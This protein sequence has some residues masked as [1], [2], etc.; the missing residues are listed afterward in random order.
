M[1]KSWHAS[2]ASVPISEE[3]KVTQNDYF[4]KHLNISL[5]IC[6]PIS[7]P[8]LFGPDG[9]STLESRLHLIVISI[10]HIF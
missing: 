3:T 9:F 8:Q 4:L 2:C 6:R 10:C 1:A 7:T 5:N